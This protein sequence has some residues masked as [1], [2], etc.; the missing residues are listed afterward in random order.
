MTST[1]TIITVIICVLLTVLFIVTVYSCWKCHRRRYLLKI[2]KLSRKKWN[3]EHCNS[4]RG[5]LIR[6][7]HTPI[8]DHYIIDK[9]IVL[10][11]GGFG[12]VVLGRHKE[13]G[14]EYALKFMNKKNEGTN[15]IE[16]EV[17][18]LK[19]VDHTNIVGL[20]SVYD[21]L[22]QVGFVLEL[23]TGGHLGTLVER[24]S[25]RQVSEEQ[26]QNLIRQLLSAVT[27]MHDRGICHRDIKLQ[28]ILLEN[29]S[30]NAQIKLID[31]GFGTRFI[32]ATPLRT[33]CG[34]PYTT[35]PEVFRENYDERCD[36]WSAGVV[37]YIV[38]CGRRPF[39][40]LHIPGELENA[41]RAAMITNILL[42]RY[43][44]NHPQWKRVSPLA[45][46][47]VQN[48]M[49]HDYRSRW[50]AKD[51]LEHEWIDP[52]SSFYMETQKTRASTVEDI[53]RILSNMRR[54]SFMSSLHKTSMLAVVF[55]QPSNGTDGLRTLF[56]NFDS[57]HN[58]TLSKE[59][60]VDAMQYMS[61]ET[62][63]PQDADTLFQAIDINNDKQIS[64]TEFLAATMD[65]REV[66]VNE[67]N[68]AFELLDIDKKG[69]ITVAD[70]LRVLDAKRHRTRS[71]R[72]LNSLSNEEQQDKEG[73]LQRGTSRVLSKMSSIGFFK[74]GRSTGIRDGSQSNASIESDFSQSQDMHANLKERKFRK[75]AELE[76]LGNE[77][78]F[79]RIGESKRECL[80]VY[81]AI[82]CTL[83]VQMT[84][85]LWRTLWTQYWLQE[86]RIY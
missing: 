34:T 42:C 36:V 84:F 16:R 37:A 44:F 47:F 45:I 11:R 3:D 21:T 19:D 38:I 31:F 18:L 27:H 64:F 63:S 72:P 30:P 8:E 52:S 7:Y 56:Q 66:D 15:R 86:Y 73:A 17:K 68:K 5:N 43:H 59:E 50:N 6:T 12:V 70:L 20:F 53:G 49:H 81:M 28:N 80:P 29:G 39:E 4:L 65:P 35:A 76:E 71:T 10:G 57:D 23:C 75:G 77:G 33:R 69:H 9:N 85:H 26:A 22:E 54:A 32:G 79:V 14:N 67:L 58:G 51:A 83:S 61:Q 2:R 55:S 62:L 24:K 74:S 1:T 60:F 41:G 25:G 46:D 82:I 13:T 40:I 78:G 48:M